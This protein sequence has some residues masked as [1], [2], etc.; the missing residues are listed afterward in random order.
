[1]ASKE[2]LVT[3]EGKRRRFRLTR[4]VGSEAEFVV[5]DR[6]P[7]ISKGAQTVHKTDTILVK[8][9]DGTF[10]RIELPDCRPED[11]V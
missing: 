9:D 6:R 5:G 1:M 7:A 4:V 2:E 8:R 3:S 10:S 11:E